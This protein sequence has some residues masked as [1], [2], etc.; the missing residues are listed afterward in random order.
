MGV[1]D[2]IQILFRIIFRRFILLNVNSIL[3]HKKRYQIFHMFRKQPSGIL[4]CNIIKLP[5]IDTPPSY[6]PV[7]HKG[8][9]YALRRFHRKPAKNYG[10]ILKW[11][12]GCIRKHL[13]VKFPVHQHHYNKIP[14]AVI[15]CEFTYIQSALPP[16]VSVTIHNLLHYILQRPAVIILFVISF[17]IHTGTHITPTSKNTQAL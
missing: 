10:K 14:H 4:R 17:H 2:Y 7:G 15:I 16:S 8:C 5:D 13:A 11:Y 12:I 6:I 1:C 3:S 9:T